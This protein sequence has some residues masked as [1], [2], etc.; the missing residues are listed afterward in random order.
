[1]ARR[2]CG[3]ASVAQDRP[4]DSARTR[5]SASVAHRPKTFP[6]G[7]AVAR[8]EQSASRPAAVAAPCVDLDLP[9]AGEQDA[10]I[11]GIHGHV[12]TARVLIDK[13]RALPRPAAVDRPEDTALR[14]RP[15]RMAKR[16][17]EDII[18]VRGIDGDAS[19]ATGF[20]ETGE[21]PGFSG[22]SGFVDAL[23]D[24]DIAADEG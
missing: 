14:L 3:S 9:H 12:G 17:R 4:F 5:R 23:A 18:R 11:P 2:S 22:V 19:N 16:T 1:S 20:V 15:V 8:P 21:R 6:C 13:Q 7:A 24:G 10:R